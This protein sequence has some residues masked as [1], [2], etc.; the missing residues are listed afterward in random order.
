L[1]Y[2]FI[3]VLSEID[4]TG[5]L[6]FYEELTKDWFSYDPL[7][8]KPGFTDYK[9]TPSIHTFKTTFDYENTQVTLSKEF[10]IMPFGSKS[11]FV[12]IKIDEMN[13]VCLMFNPS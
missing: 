10:S 9:M 6:T 5:P 12:E 13:P 2:L 7:K 1:I 8:K 11:I 4:V 3:Y